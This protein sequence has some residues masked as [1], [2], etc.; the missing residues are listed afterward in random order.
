MEFFADLKK[1]THAVVQSKTDASCFEGYKNF[2]VHRQAL[3]SYIKQ[4]INEYGHEFFGPYLCFVHLSKS[5]SSPKGN[6]DQS[7]I[8]KII[9][10]FDQ[11]EPD[12]AIECLIYLYSNAFYFATMFQ[13]DLL[14]NSPL[15]L[16]LKEVDLPEREGQRVELALK[17]KI[18]ETVS[19]YKTLRPKLASLEAT[20]DEVRLAVKYIARTPKRESVIESL[21]ALLPLPPPKF[22]WDVRP[23]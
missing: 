1:L 19:F 15:T 9:E 7:S 12:R 11:V 20:E 3:Y 6:H 4:N 8:L 22:S 18:L 10:L 2:Q 21:Q 16:F 17:I 14:E 13:A 5:V 23:T